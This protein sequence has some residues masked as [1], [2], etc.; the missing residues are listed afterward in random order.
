MKIELSIVMPC[1]NEIETIALCI[2]KAHEL[3]FPRKKY[4]SFFIF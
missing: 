1:L 2:S 4:I 3:A